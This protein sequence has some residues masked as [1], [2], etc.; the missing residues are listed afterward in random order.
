[1]SKKT[2][3]TPLSKAIILRQQMNLLAGSSGVQAT[4]SGYETEADTW[5]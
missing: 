2:Y 3:Q 1:M 5:E 4:R